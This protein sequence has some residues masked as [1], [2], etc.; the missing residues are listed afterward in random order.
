MA[1][2]RFFTF[3]MVPVVLAVFA[4]GARAEPGDELVGTWEGTSGGYKETWTIARD[5]DAWSVVGSFKLGEREVGSFRGTN[6]KLA[7]GALGF[8]QDFIRKPAA[9]WRSGNQMTARAAEDTLTITW[10]NGKATGNSTLTRSKGDVAPMKEEPKKLSEEAQK[11]LSKL[12]GKWQFKDF[13]LDGKKIDFGAVWQ[14]KGET[15]VETIGVPRRSGTLKVE[16]GK[17]PKEIDVNFTKS[18]GGMTGLFRGVY[19]LEGDKLT[20]CLGTDG[21]RPEKLESPAESKTMLIVFQ[22][23]K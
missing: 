23:G 6:V 4:G 14:F 15:V 9:N 5:K 21:K 10:R 20:V 8:R 7:G 1:N 18:N 13:M 12:E 3:L 22:R 11:E 19:E 16:P 2:A 17:S